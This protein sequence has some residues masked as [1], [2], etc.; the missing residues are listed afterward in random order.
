MRNSALNSAILSNSKLALLLL[1]LVLFGFET[2]QGAGPY[3]ISWYTVD[4]GGGT[5][6]GG[7]Y[8]LTGT[9]GQPDAEWCAGGTYELLGGFLPGGP[10]QPG[11][12]FP[13]CRADYDT[14]L[15]AGSPEC[16][17]YPRQCHSDA[18]GQSAGSAK[19]GVYY[20]GPADLNILVEAWMVREAPFGPGIASVENGICADFAHDRGGSGKSGFY[21][22]G[23]T[24]LSILIANWL[25]KEP[26]YGPG[27]EPDCLACP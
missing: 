11:E 14:W 19:A 15:T 4:S 7:P 26:P 5:N 2:A 24:D 10:I 3:H 27:I 22:V 16:W 8:A 25:V 21:R 23:P 17:C 20:V 12:C 1:C 18:D 13:S 6:K 9:I